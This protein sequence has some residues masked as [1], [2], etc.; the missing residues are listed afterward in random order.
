MGIDREALASGTRPRID[1]GA[2]LLSRSDGFD[3]YEIT[4]Y[5][6]MVWGIS[7]RSKDVGQD[8]AM[9]CKSVV[10]GELQSYTAMGDETRQQA[11]DR[12]IAMA[13]RRHANGIIDIQFALEGAAGQTQ[14]TVYG[15]AVSIVPIE[16]Y[17]PAGAVGNILAELTDT[18]SA[19]RVRGRS[20][21]E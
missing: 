3:G 10:G 9:S 12:M 17:V 2:V 16:D 19:A 18:L 13:K 8:I 5:H 20:G 15:C 6:G 11:V 21:D 7:V 14:V 1:D 4:Q